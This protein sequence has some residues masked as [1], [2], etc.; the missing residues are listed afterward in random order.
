MLCICAGHQAGPQGP[1]GPPGPPGRD[2]LPGL[3]G[4]AFGTY[5]INVQIHAQDTS[6][7]TFFFTDYSCFAEYEQRT[8]YGAL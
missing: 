4:Y 1:P 2:G 6:V 7:L 3:P 5:I 8:L